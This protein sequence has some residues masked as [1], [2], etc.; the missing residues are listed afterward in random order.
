MFFYK[1][2]SKRKCYRSKNILKKQENRMKRTEIEQQSLNKI[3]EEASAPSFL[4]FNSKNL[5]YLKN[6]SNL[7]SLFIHFFKPHSVSHTVKFVF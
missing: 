4:L 1:T 7:K 5:F 6:Y 2:V 3:K